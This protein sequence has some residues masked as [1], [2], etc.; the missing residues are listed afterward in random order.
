M[1]LQLAS[2]TIY[3]IKSSGGLSLSCA[4][5]EPRGLA[6]DR[7]WMIVDE[8]ARFLTGR[9][10]P[11]LVMLR[12]RPEDGGLVLAAAGR[13]N[14]RV[15]V[16]PASAPRLN[17]TVWGDTVD[18]VVAGADA[19]AWLS[20]FLQRP[21]RLVYMDPAARRAVDPERARPGDEVSFADGYPLLLI[22]Q[23]S[24]D[25][26]NARLR[27]P[28]PMARFRPNLVVGGSEPHAEDGWRRV[29]IGSIEFE[30]VKPC[31]RCVFTTVDPDSGSF[32][33]DREPLNTLLTYRRTP[34]GVT[35]GQNLIARGSGSLRVGDAVE[36]D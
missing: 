27:R 1:A 11:S 31:V 17:V 32:D 12:A 13:S 23:G 26:L 35:F 30:A 5:V 2:I 10:S 33:P 4:A 25:G 8:N 16:P 28:V 6:H 14:L 29:R 34:K 15:E 19:S 24:L 21:V 9:Q 36:V 7:R 20:D 3:P 18:A 22:G